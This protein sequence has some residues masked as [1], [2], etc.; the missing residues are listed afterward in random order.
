MSHAGDAGDVPDALVNLRDVATAHACLRA[1]RLF[2]S[3]APLPG[4]LTGRE[5]PDWPPR[6]VLDLR[7]AAE[8]RHDH[9]Y[10]A[11]SEIVALPIL[12]GSMREHGGPPLGLADLYRAMVGGPA[13]SMLADAVSLIAAREGP[14]LVHCS[15]GKDRTGITVA[16]TLRLLDVDRDSIAADYAR[17]TEAMPLVLARLAATAGVRL[18]DPRMAE[19]PREVFEAPAHAIQEVLDVFDDHPGGAAGWF[20]AHGGDAAAIDALARR[21]LV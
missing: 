7:D 2:R 20:T 4:D 3:D 21:L 10:A 6:L 11:L 5:V 14:V 15:A 17:T 13:A 18:D 19:V 9:P 16:L 12:E 8:K 1:G